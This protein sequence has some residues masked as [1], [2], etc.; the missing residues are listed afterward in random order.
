MTQ[1]P[2]DS[3]NCLGHDLQIESHRSFQAPRS[4]VLGEVSMVSAY[5]RC[6]VD[7]Q[8]FVLDLEDSSALAPNIVEAPPRKVLLYH[9]PP[10]SSLGL[11][12]EGEVFER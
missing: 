1:L 2:T 8:I 9:Q 5:G 11:D 12:L 6:L 4:L 10:D 3:R 7:R